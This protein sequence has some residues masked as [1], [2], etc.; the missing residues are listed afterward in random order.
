[1]RNSK[2][3][4]NFGRLYNKGELEKRPGGGG[5]SRGKNSGKNPDRKMRHGEKELCDA[6]LWI[7][8]IRESES[9]QRGMGEKEGMGIER[10]IIYEVCGGVKM[11]ASKV[12]GSLSL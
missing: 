7:K 8:K 12:R 9:E 2:E 5:D 11:G 1:L 10:Y 6:K 4:I 3:G